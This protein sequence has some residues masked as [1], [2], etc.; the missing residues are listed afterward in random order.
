MTDDFRSILFGIEILERC[1][2]HA[3]SFPERS[4][5]LVAPRRCGKSTLIHRFGELTQQ[6][7][8]DDPTGLE[9]AE[10]LQA[11]D[12]VPFLIV[13]TPGEQ[14]PLVNRAQ[15]ASLKKDK[16]FTI[17]DMTTLVGN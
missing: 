7:V 10:E 12:G 8:L 6:K 1:F 2:I 13:L 16:G 15:I 17:L 5:C 4:F 14:H 11:N 9:L 3:M